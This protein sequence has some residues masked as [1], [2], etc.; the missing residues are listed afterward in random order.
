VY[1]E[2]SGHGC[3]DPMTMGIINRIFNAGTI[4][5]GQRFV[6]GQIPMVRGSQMDFTLNDHGEMSIFKFRGNVL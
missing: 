6:A 4:P 5:Y 2:K 1:F 3:P